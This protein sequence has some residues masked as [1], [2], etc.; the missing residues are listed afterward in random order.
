M[1]T[2]LNSLNVALHDV[3]KQD[4]RVYVMGEDILDPYGGAFKVTRGLSSSFPDRV[5]TTPVSEAGM[6]GIAAGMALRGL[7]PVIEIMFGDFFTLIADQLVNHITKFRWM[8]NN[9]VTVPIVIRT[10]MGGRRGYGPTHSQSLEKIYLGIPGLRVIA[11]NAIGD[12]GMLL[13]DAI[14]IDDNPVV[15][16]ENK[17]LYSQTLHSIDL[18]NHFQIATESGQVSTEPALCTAD[19]APTYIIKIAGAPPP[20]LTIVCY[21][22]MAEL[23]LEASK[24]LAY[25]SEIFT[26]VVVPTQLAPY[27][28]EPIF[29]SVKQ[30]Q[31]I[32]VVEEGTRTLGWGTEVLAR[33]SEKYGGYIVY[34]NRL[35]AADL[36]IPASRH[37]EEQVLPKVEDIILTAQSSIK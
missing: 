25:E 24:Y 8:Y 21:G 1:T 23:V 27:S 5:L 19:Y 4:A 36:P 33:I 3:M 9:Q 18:L 15:F 13:A 7:R 31:R 10:P 28:M 34:S 2:V 16:I 26:E 30:T 11:L 20:V 6:V 12:P 29:E 37:L 22:Y 17:L 14:L 35:G 32:V